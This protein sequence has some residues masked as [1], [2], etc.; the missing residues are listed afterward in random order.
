M[1]EDNSVHD[2]VSCVDQ[3]V[4]LVH[5]LS[6]FVRMYAWGLKF[7]QLCFIQV[8]GVLFEVPQR[9]F[10]EQS[11]VFRDMFSHNPE[12]KTDVHPIRL[13]GIQADDFRAL[14]KFMFHRQATWAFIFRF[15]NI[16]T[17]Y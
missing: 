1:S 8:E 6:F 10:Q 2:S 9:P 4:F 15:I 3:V 14:L 5:F 16:N 17:T 11:E 12:G 13:E 7:L